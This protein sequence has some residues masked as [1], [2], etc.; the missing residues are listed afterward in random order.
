[1]RREKWETLQSQLRARGPWLIAFSGGADSTFLVAAAAR[2]VGPKNV[3]AVT[4]VSA[5]LAENERRDTETLAQLLGVPYQ[6]LFTDELLNPSYASNPPN[7]CFY[8]KE[9]LFRK[10][11]PLA[12]ECGMTV[13]DGF[14][15]S[16]RRDYRP[17]FQAAQKWQVAHP[18]DEAGLEKSD[19][20]MLSRWLKL[21]TWN[22]PASPC[23]SSRIPYGQEVTPVRLKQIELAEGAVRALGFRVV[24]VRHYDTEARIEVP[25]KD[26]PRL[27]EP[28]RWQE[29]TR[30]V[31]ACGYALVTA[32]SRGF[33]SGRLNL[34]TEKVGTISM[35]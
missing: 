22:K 2:A 13:A 25:I 23:L 29:V 1:M 7:R 11:A 6:P 33:Q 14:N 16:D 30:Q 35:K 17:G 10:L 21:P 26:L 18:L 3:L 8:C 32:D 28:A 15:V 24:R 20:R 19:I 5:S 9:E 27:L 4:A 31:L 34:P 12:V